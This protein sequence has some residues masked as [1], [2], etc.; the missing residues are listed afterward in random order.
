LA[1]ESLKAILLG[2]VEGIT[3]WLPISSTGHM[4]LLDALLKLK[5]SD[6]FM[7]LFLV[8]IQLGAV[9]AVVVLYFD[10][11]VPFEFSPK[12]AWRPK[13]IQLWLKILAASVPA[14][15]VGILWDDVF[16][17][18]FYNPLCVS[19]ALIVFGVL[20]IVIENKKRKQLPVLDDTDAMDYKTAVMLGLFQLIAA[21][22]PGTSRSGAIIIGALL[23]GISRTAAAEFAFFMAIPAMAGGSL[24][25]LMRVGLSFTGTEW[26][27]LLIG[28]IAA[29]I[30][31]VLTI[32]FLMQYIRNHDFTVFGWYRIV[33]GMLVLC[34]FAIK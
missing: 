19:L 22:F 18:L 24:L 23:L 17:A 5:V 32:R 13:T 9:L 2:L 30:V 25:R 7:E 21:V 27:L 31:S 20:F 11:L 12:L 15:I 10:R 1:I 26:S 4:I 33:L 3:E 14:A 8:L 28:T 29:F 6:Q 34:C 16:S